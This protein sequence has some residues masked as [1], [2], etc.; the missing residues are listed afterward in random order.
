MICERKNEGLI[1]VFNALY[2]RFSGKIKDPLLDKLVVVL[3]ECLIDKDIPDKKVHLELLK[4]LC[5]KH[6]AYLT[7][8]ISDLYYLIR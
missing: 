1:K 2:K 5:H 8:V 6:S 3:K 7:P 4:N